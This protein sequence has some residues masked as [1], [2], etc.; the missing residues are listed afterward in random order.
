MFVRRRVALLAVSIAAA[1]SIAPMAL[2]DTGEIIE[3]QHHPATAADGWQ[4]GTCT[5]DTPPCSPTTESQF[6]K[7]AGGHPPIGFTQYTIQHTETT[8]KVEPAGIPF[9][10]KPIKEPEADR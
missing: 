5:T 1:L 10:T 2:A 3:P 9:T 4:A 8:G 7:I 6:F